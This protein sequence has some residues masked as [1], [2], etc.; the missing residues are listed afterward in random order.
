MCTNQNYLLLLGLIMKTNVEMAVHI[1]LVVLL[2]IMMC[3]YAYI[4]NIFS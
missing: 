3:K 1:F 4:E 2:H